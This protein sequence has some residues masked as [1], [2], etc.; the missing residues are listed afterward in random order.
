MK[1]AGFGLGLVFVNFGVFFVFIV[2]CY[3]LLNMLLFLNRRGQG[4]YRRFA[5][6]CG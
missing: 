2:S 3:F 1:D 5:M 4:K 6:V